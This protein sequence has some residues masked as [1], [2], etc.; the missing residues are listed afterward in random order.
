M[1]ASGVGG[2]AKLEKI[3]ADTWPPQ[4]GGSLRTET[5]IDA[6]FPV[7]GGT[8]EIVTKY[9]GLK[10]DTQRGDLCEFGDISC[11]LPEG[12]NVVVNEGVFPSSSPAGSYA[13]RTEVKASD[14]RVVYCYIVE[15]NAKK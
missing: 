4:F 6:T 12:R 5:F 1:I 2:L 3:T 13:M 11:P 8:W 10:V 9:N 7:T 15:F 14:G